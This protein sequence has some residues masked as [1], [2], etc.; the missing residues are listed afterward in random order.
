MYILI[1]SAIDFLNLGC[2][3]FEVK[4]EVKKQLTTET[5][6]I[7]YINIKSHCVLRNDF[8][9]LSV[10]IIAVYNIAVCPKYQT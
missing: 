3:L 8:Y 1:F 2:V 10:M 7:K 4:V 5:P 6:K 9:E